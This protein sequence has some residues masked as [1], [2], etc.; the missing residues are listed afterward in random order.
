MKKQ[1][2]KTMVLGAAFIINAS[3]SAQAA[4]AQQKDWTMLVYLNG[5]NNL[6]YYGK[7][8]INQMETVGSNDHLN[9]VVQWASESADNTRRLYV[10][11][12]NDTN[13][14]TSPVVQSL[15]TVDMGDVNSLVDFVKW[16]A[17][18]YPA[19]H[20][21]VVVWDHGAGWHSLNALEGKR[22]NPNDISWDDNTGHYIT[23]EQLGQAMNQ[24][25]QIIGHPVDIYGSDACLMAMI[26]IAQ[27][28]AGAVN[29][30]V[31][32]EE[33]EPGAGWPYDTFLA[34][35]ANHPEATAADIGKM[36]TDAYAKQYAIE[37]EEQATFSAFD[38][39]KLPELD[40]KIA[41]LKVKLMGLS[42]LSAVQQAAASSVRFIDNDYVDLGDA[43]LNIQKALPANTLSNEFQAVTE[44]LHEVVIA[45]GA[46]T[47]AQGLSIWWPTDG[48]D[49][50]Q[51][52]ER[53]KGLKFNQITHWHEFL[54]AIVPAPGMKAKN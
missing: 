16:G 8:N 42:N 18:N 13:N 39:S 43:I 50:S 33:T 29:V 2:I 4:P 31:G 14:V 23:T 5:H 52:E 28:M 6:D 25:A 47:P 37:G 40:G 21:F 22:M 53:Y 32:S 24:A 10:Q 7:L 19:K 17:E 3:F 51:N 54:S 48:Y 1:I 36:L 35:W 9:I 34:N 45:N 15:P 12:D 11:K 49:W 44:K 41:D 46:N 38:M 30:F 26:E 20:Y 27:E